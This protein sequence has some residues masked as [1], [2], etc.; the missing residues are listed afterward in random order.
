[1]RNKK[2]FHFK[3]NIEGINENDNKHTKTKVNI[4]IMKSLGEY[5]D[6]YVL[7]DILLLADIFEILPV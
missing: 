2:G 7:S 4:F 5:P 3:L 1:M 6:L